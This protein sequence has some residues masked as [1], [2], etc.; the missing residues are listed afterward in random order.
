MK[1]SDRLKMFSLKRFVRLSPVASWDGALCTVLLEKN[2]D[3][4]EPAIIDPKHSTTV[5]GEI[6]GRNLIS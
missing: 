2:R 4:V 3:D 6:F 5:K 1:S